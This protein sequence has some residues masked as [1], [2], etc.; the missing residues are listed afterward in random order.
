MI[1]QQKRDLT[2]VAY[3][4]AWPAEFQQEAR[5]LRQALG[6]KALQIE[7][8]G[9]TSVPGL[10]AKPIIDIAV[11]VASLA[12]ARP[13]IPILEALGYEYKPLDTV[14]ERLFFAREQ[15]P[16]FR[17]HHL[18]LSEPDSGFWKNKLAFRDYLQA[19]DD[20]AAEYVELKHQLAAEYARTGILP[21]DGKTAFVARVLALAES[22]AGRDT[23]ADMQS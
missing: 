20:L 5:R 9:S 16:E 23:S 13:L 6:D 22:A 10:A 1:G 3:R 18:N 15:G 8:I 4:D 2:V 17:T 12:Q 19:H 14:P 21:T 11:A 7:H